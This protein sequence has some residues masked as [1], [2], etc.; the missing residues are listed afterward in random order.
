MVRSSQPASESEGFGWAGRASGWG[1]VG[2]CLLFRAEG[3]WGCCRLRP[4][5]NSSGAR[6]HPAVAPARPFRGSGNSEGGT[7]ISDHAGCV[8]AAAD[9]NGL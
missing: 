9:R 1:G 3:A 6:A 8:G 5:Q 2:G 7:E 4:S